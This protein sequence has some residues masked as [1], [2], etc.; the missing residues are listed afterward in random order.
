MR[1]AVGIAFPSRE[2]ELEG[3]TPLSARSAYPGFFAAFFLILLR[4][5]IGW[6]FLYEGVYKIEK[7]RSNEP[8]SSEGYLRNATGPLAERFRGMVP[9]VY[10]LERLDPAKLQAMWQADAQRIAQ[11]YGFDSEQQAKADQALKNAVN[12]AR[13]WFAAPENA[14]KVRQYRD[15]LTR[16]QGIESS[17]DALWF[18]VE[19]GRQLR[20]KAETTRRELAAVVD[21]WT[22]EVKNAL[23]VLAAPEQIMSKGDPRRNFWE[24]N[25]LE[26]IDAVTTFGLAA[27]GFCM[28]AGLFT[29]P[30]ILG[31][32]GFLTLFYLSAPPWPGLPQSPMAEGHYLYV[33]KNL[34]ELLA[35]LVLLSFPTGRWIGLDAAIFEGLARRRAA[36]R[37]RREQERAERLGL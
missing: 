29:R 34:I 31:A 33:N 19:N 25:S 22:G 12:K 26:R 3:E 35:C 5:G 36:A 13:D 27:V 11:H 15:D 23:A 7:L 9:D 30:A 10:A 32:I 24:M 1:F 28:I 16:A 14:L 17:A 21:G 37:A 6:H 4:I 2:S 20:G 18:Q 8:F